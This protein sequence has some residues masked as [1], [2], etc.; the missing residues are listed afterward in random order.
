MLQLKTPGVYVQEL[1]SG[2]KT[3]SGA[4]TSV[5]V[6]LGQS[7]FPSGSPR[8]TTVTATLKDASGVTANAQTTQA[9]TFSVDNGGVCSISPTNATIS[10][11]AN[12][13]TSST[14]DVAATSHDNSPNAAGRC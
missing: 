7:E 13:A 8:T 9:V 6:S 12:S 10:A 11:G 14:P 1:P 4:P 2:V 5:A 3:V